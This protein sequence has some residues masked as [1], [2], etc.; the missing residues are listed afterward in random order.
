VTL[1]PQRQHHAD[2]H[3]EALDQITPTA[4]VA[5]AGLAKH[6]TPDTHITNERR[7][8]RGACVSSPNMGHL[9]APVGVLTLSQP[10]VTNHRNTI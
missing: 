5:P 1:P 10:F 2:D 3:T 4:V 7:S 8:D 9:L 6:P